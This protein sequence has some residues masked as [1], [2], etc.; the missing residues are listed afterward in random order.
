MK[1]GGEISMKETFFWKDKEKNILKAE[2]FSTIADSYAKEI[3]SDNDKCNKYTQI[4]KFYEEILPYKTDIPINADKEIFERKIPY[5]KM[6]NA[7]LAYSAAR[8]HISNK[9]CCF[10]QGLVNEINDPADFYAFVDFFEA[11]LAFYKQYKRD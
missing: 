1:I 2:L 4:R 9:C 6:L 5:I 3:S 11:F 7:R 8:L 10:F